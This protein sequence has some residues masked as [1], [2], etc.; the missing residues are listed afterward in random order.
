MKSLEPDERL[1]RALAEWRVTPRRDA[2]FRASVWARI[3]ATR[4]TS[5]WMGYARA[6]AV[7]L[8]SAMALA[9]VLGGWAGFFLTFLGVSGGIGRVYR[10]ARIISILSAISAGWCTLLI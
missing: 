4:R 9:L 1:A 3:E 7:G 6:H 10:K 8:A 2:L 5:S